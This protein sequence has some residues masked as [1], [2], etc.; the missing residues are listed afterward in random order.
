MGDLPDGK[1]LSSAC[2]FARVAQWIL[3]VILGCLFWVL[4]QVTYRPG[5]LLGSGPGKTQAVDLA[6][7]AAAQAQTRTG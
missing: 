1:E 4:V 5:S 2:R 3:G 6:A 7:T